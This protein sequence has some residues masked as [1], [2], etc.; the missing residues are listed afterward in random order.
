MN[1]TLWA[2]LLACCGGDAWTSAPESAEQ[3]F[4][5]GLVDRRLF[6]LADLACRNELARAGLTPRQQVEWTVELIRVRSQQAAQVAPD[7]RNALWAAAHA[8]ASEFLAQSSAHPQR[9]LVEVQDALTTLAAGELA[10]WESEVAA[11]PDAAREEART[12]IR[13]AARALE[14]LDQQL[15]RALAEQASSTAERESLAEDELFALQNH[16]RFQLARALRNQALCYPPDSDDRIAALNSAIAQLGR[17]LRQL[18]PTDLLAL[19]VY[20]DLATCQRL[21][22]D[23]AAARAALDGPLSDSAPEPIRL[24]AAAETAELALAAGQPQQAL[25]IVQQAYDKSVPPTPELD[26][27]RLLALLTL[28]T[29]TPADDPDPPPSPWQEQAVAAVRQLEQTHGPYWGRRGELELLRV[30]GSGVGTRSVEVLSRTADNLYLQGAYD[31]AIVAYERAARQARIGGDAASAFELEY[32]AGLIEQQR[33]RYA[34]AS[35]RFERLALDQPADGRAAATHL[36]AAWNAAQAARAERSEAPRY[37]QLLEQQLARWPLAADTHTARVWLGKLRATEQH[38]EA[39]V[40]AYR[41]IPADAEPFAAMLPELVRCWERWIDQQRTDDTVP[42][43][44]VADAVQYFDRV[45]LSPDGTWPASWTAAQRAAAL[46]T[47]R[48]RLAYVREGGAD[49]ERA[50]RAALE[51]TPAEEDTWR[52]SAQSLLVVALASQPGRAEEAS[53]L[54][55]TLSAGSPDRLVEVAEGLSRIVTL[56]PRQVQESLAALQLAAADR[57]QQSQV[58][59]DDAQ[60]LRVDQLRA[61]A[62]HTLARHGEALAVLRGLATRAPE[63]RDIQLRYGSALLASDDPASADAA[64]THWQ[65]LARRLRPET[66]DWYRAKYSFALALFQRN[67]QRDRAVAGQQLRYL[68][69]TSQVDRS[70]WKQQVDELL[71]RCPP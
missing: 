7:A 19:Q 71:Q 29:G 30:A 59:L 18:Q 54:L 50:L 36:L 65:Q 6:A 44:L 60:R 64:V 12:S 21:L 67:R 8:A 63:D 13:Q 23:L 27:V 34:T 70:S 45:I 40:A 10:R 2:V 32:K 26:F 22:G 61:E 38:W 35:R 52:A 55:E 15:T 37:A 5:H 1:A 4:V 14:E 3:Q 57:L 16:V 49:A 58:V 66:D 20:L 53:T 24:R 51:Q 47:A 46:A 33:E 62:L 42:R 11:V 68:K 31:D 56:A 48:L 43:E 39:A 69:A 41:G 17:T 9:I 28:W 25:E